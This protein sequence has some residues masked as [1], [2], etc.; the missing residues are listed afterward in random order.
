MLFLS[1]NET[2]DGFREAAL[3]AKLPK[4]TAKNDGA[5]PPPPEGDANKEKSGSKEADA[6]KGAPK[7][8][9][10]K[11]GDG[12]KNAAPL[13]RAQAAEL[14]SDFRLHRHQLADVDAGNIGADR[15][16]L[17]PVLDRGFGF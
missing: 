2:S 7:S 13:M 8:S 1:G 14:I 15:P 10:P 6:K 9:V 17:S 16:E 11:K 4:S 3:M 5:S 12:S